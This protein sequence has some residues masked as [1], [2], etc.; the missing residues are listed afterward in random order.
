MSFIVYH[1]LDLNAGDVALHGRHDGRLD[2]F[3]ADLHL[4]HD[5]HLLHHVHGLLLLNTSQEVP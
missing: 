2:D 5:R 3:V 4:L 1:F